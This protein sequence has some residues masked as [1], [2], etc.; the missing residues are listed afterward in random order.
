MYFNVFKDHLAWYKL[1]ARLSEQCL[2]ACTVKNSD[3]FDQT[4]ANMVTERQSNNSNMEKISDVDETART[5]INIIV[6]KPAAAPTIPINMPVNF[7]KFENT[8]TVSSLI[9]QVKE[10]TAK[11]KY[12]GMS[13][14][15]NET[16]DTFIS[17]LVSIL[18]FSL[19][20]FFCHI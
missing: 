16:D 20:Q 4:V 8:L 18:K 1:H 2:I 17:D 5:E 11:G 15:Y 7:Y 6:T 19:D 10:N 14:S 13:C 12:S 3:H 9:E